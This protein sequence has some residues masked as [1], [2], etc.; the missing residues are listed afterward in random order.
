MN[1]MTG[2]N[3]TSE[4]WREY[5]WDVTV[6]GRTERRIYRINRPQLLFTRSGGRTHRVSDIDGIVHCV[7]G[8]GV[9]GCVL[10]WCPVDPKNPC[11]F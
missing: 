5:E 9:M 2:K 4:L 1:D 6:D 11:Q 7:P 8:V 10:R 3:I